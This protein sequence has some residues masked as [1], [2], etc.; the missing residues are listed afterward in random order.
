MTI[1]KAADSR[2]SKIMEKEKVMIDIRELS[3]IYKG[4]GQAV[5]ALEGINLQ[6]SRGEFLCVA[7]P[8]GSGKSTLLNLIGALDSPS[9]GNIVV[10]GRE[11]TRLNRSR[12]AL[13]RRYN[14][15]FVF[16]F[17]NLIPVL[18]AYE[19][20]EYPLLLQGVSAAKRKNRVQTA[21]SD[22]GISELAGKRPQALSGGQQQRVA[23]ARA[24]VGR[25][26]IILADEP[27]GSLDSKSSRELLALFKHLNSAHKITFCFSSHDPE[28]IQQASRVVI[29]KDGRITPS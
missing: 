2:F 12:R 7:G 3:R 13:F 28:V 17:F 22:V 23:V 16:Q 1:S 8:S 19:N 9:S 24:I 14:I 26:S 18:T 11:I 5:V 4:A 20:I 27:T 15:G 29:L 10:N 6:I 25:P 21:L